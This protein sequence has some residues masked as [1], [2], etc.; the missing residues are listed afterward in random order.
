LTASDCRLPQR[1]W[2]IPLDSAICR[3]L[4]RGLCMV[5]EAEAVA[6]A[7]KSAPVTAAAAPESYSTATTCA[8]AKASASANANSGAATG[9][10]SAAEFPAQLSLEVGETPSAGQPVPVE[11]QAGEPPMAPATAVEA[12]QQLLDR[13]VD[14]G[15]RPLPATFMVRP[16]HSFIRIS[17]HS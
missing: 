11:A 15:I 12:A 6:E 7:D 8:S 14:L 17:T 4:I 1:D 5:A 16:T 9:S 10:D 2:E 13:H 3:E